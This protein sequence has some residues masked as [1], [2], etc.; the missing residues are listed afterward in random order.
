MGGFVVGVLA[1]VGMAFAEAIVAHFARE[2]YTYLRS[3]HA[4]AAAA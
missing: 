1:R 4:A 2:L 3:R